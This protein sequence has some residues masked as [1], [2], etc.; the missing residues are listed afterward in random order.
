MAD[1]KD[2]RNSQFREGG[3]S[4]KWVQVFPFQPA[5]SGAEGRA[6][7][8]LRPVLILTAV[9]GFVLCKACLHTFLFDSHTNTI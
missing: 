5:A 3:K 8:T 4:K 7:E 2:E 9:Q 6:P 1:G